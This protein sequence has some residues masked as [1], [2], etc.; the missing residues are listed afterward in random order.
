MVP[1]ENFKRLV[2][3]S[4]W[5]GNN[6]YVPINH[7]KCTVWKIFTVNDAFSEV[8]SILSKPD[9]HVEIC[10]NDNVVNEEVNMVIFN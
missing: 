8:I 1:F 9:L 2:S 10:V 7:V 6:K 3:D 4:F 5:E